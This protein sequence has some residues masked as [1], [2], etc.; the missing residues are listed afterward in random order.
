MSV[1]V[2]CTVEDMN[3][4]ACALQVGDWFELSPTG[5]TVPEGKNG[6]ATSPL[7]P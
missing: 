5:L 2:R 1:T 4:S 3:Y 7:P 6:S